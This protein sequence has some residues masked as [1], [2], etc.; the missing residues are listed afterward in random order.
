MARETARGDT[1]ALWAL[2]AAATILSAALA[3]RFVSR[4]STRAALVLALL[5]LLLTGK[6]ML[7]GRVYGPADLLA[8]SVPWSAAV[9]P[10]PRNVNPI[11]SDLAFANLPWRAA[12]RESVSN[13]RFPFWN[14]FVLGGNPLLAAAQAGVFH[15]ATWLGIL[16]PLPLSWTFS[17]AFTLFL[18]LL[19]GYLFFRDLALTEPPAL[20]GAAGWGLSTY[21]VFWNGW[22]VGPATAAFP[23]LLLGLRRLARG[24]ERGVAITVAAWLLSLAGGH[25][26]S[27]FHASAAAGLYFAAELVIRRRAGTTRRALGGAVAAAAL[28]ALFSGPQLFPLLEAIPRTAEYRVRSRAIAAGAASQSV[29]APQAAARL[30]PAVLP[31]AH[32]IYGKSPVQAEREDGSGMPLAY[33][34]A[35]LFPFAALGLGRRREGRA[36]FAAAAAAGLLLGASAPGLIDLLTRFP[37]F[38]LALNYRL[39]FLAGFGISGLAALGAE[40]VLEDGAWRRLA[41][42]SAACVL[43]LAAAVLAARTL[44]HERGLPFGFV[45]RQATF[46]IAPLALLALAALAWRR[47]GA[48]VLAAGI[49]LLAAQRALEMGGTYPARPRTELAPPL[50]ELDGVRR[51]PGRVVGR[52]GDLRPNGA[53]LLG[54]EDVRGYESIVLDRFADTF[55]L[56]CVPQ[57]ASFNRVDDL[58]R[59]FLGFLSARFAVG[60]PGAAPPPGW[61]VRGRSA[62]LSLFENP[63]ALGRAFAPRRVVAEPDASRLLSAM[64]AS[65]DFAETAWV[66]SLPGA[67][68]ALANPPAEISARRAGT[69]LV[70]ET[71]AP[72]RVPLFVATSLPDWPGWRVRSDRS[73]LETVTVNHAF[74]GF[75]LP[76]GTLRARLSYVPPSF[77]AGLAACAIGL[78]AV[79]A[80]SMLRR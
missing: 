45:V 13:G 58:A 66:S 48:R 5:P 11:L 8:G 14:R 15:P 73:R 31:F 39:V 23:L 78:F 34:G 59:P 32:G 12:V 76:P 2:Y 53:A 41:I 25:P 46:E 16:L 67:A 33:A 9:A 77:P 61:R 7:L 55:P 62:S 60:P 71:R 19:A 28:A 69:D 68:A 43:V 35:V 21:L 38:A 18:G 52:G 3:T 10:P 26:E 6:A 65:N 54:L 4:V 27:L 80:H 44:F 57:P 20:L 79:A 30:V 22:S 75:W 51:D 64:G 50:P 37:G 36:L 72:S 56:W 49:V 74:V 70:V 47:N 63:R 42:V 17:C 29:A 40:R 24:G 1:I